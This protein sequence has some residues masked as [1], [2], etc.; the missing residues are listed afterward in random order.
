MG[1]ATNVL[2]RGKK[3]K[4]REWLAADRAV[5]ARVLLEPVC[6]RYPRD[7]EVWCLLGQAQGQTGAWAEAHGSLR[8]AADLAPADPAVWFF[9]GNTLLVLG[10][11]SEA[12]S[13]Y[14]RALEHN[15]R[16]P[17]ALSNLGRA[18][19]LEGRDVEAIECFERALALEPGLAK[20]WGILGLSRRR[21]GRPLEA[22]ACF[23]RALELQPGTSE[24]QRLLGQTLA[25]VGEL[26]EAE[27]CLQGVLR[28]QPDSA[29]V[30]CELG[31]VYRL[32]G[33]FKDAL[34]AYRRA[35]V[36]A[37][38]EA[39]ARAGEAAVL[40][41]LGRKDEAR[42][43]VGELLARGDR[44]PGT[45]E[46]HADLCPDDDARGAVAVLIRERLVAGDLPGDGR[47]RLLFRLGQL[48]DRRG[49]YDEA[50]AAWD[51]ANGLVD[52]EFDGAAH[53]RFVDRIIETFSREAFARLPRSS[54]TESGPVFIVGMPRSGTSLVEQILACH[55]QVYGAGELPWLPRL[56]D[57]PAAT[58]G[59]TRAAFPGGVA[60]VDAAALDRMAREYLRLSRTGSDAARYV[61]DKLPVNF[62]YLG[63]IALLFPGARIVHCA[64]DPRD[65]ALSL[66]S[67]SFGLRLPFAYRLGDI[68]AFYREYARL[69]RHW[70]QVLPLP[71]HTVQ[72]EEL[73]RDPKPVIR[74][75]L[76]FLDLD[77]EPACREPHRSGRVIATASYD[78]VRTPIYTRS[79]GRWRY[80]ERYLGDLLAVLGGPAR[81]PD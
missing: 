42:R 70:E 13:V 34:D 64:R 16:W 74:R 72:Y 47:T 75:L 35:P 29:G 67:Q 15:S 53:R 26:E 61:T 71:L 66:Y 38:D 46:V 14:R 6:A 4:A 32:Q 7:P 50:F 43:I 19:Q 37:P 30:W 51:E 45:L 23:R 63:L 1:S 17:Q 76:V 10:R 73:A 3:R 22:V 39:G 9:L 25:D 27:T 11:F 49:E 60:A 69:M 24:I 58:P 12:V 33:R 52:I 79:V 44:T 8:R 59:G 36:R 81:G 2:L 41:M 21:C 55:S 57:F 68:A 20:T 40:E 54:R 77:W 18:L 65:T 31:M 80:Y 5:E 28:A 48:H 78:Q 56:A 62:L